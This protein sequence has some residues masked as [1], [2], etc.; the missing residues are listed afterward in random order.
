[1]KSKRNRFT[2]FTADFYIEESSRVLRIAGFGHWG[3][4][5][6]FFLPRFLEVLQLLNELEGSF[7]HEELLIKMCVWRPLV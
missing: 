2:F 4:V 7:F 6:H 1:M 5:G 3:R